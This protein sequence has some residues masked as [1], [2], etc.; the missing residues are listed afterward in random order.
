MNNIK[1]GEGGGLVG[2]Q[3]AYW[4]RGSG[5][6]MTSRAWDVLDGY[7]ALNIII[8]ALRVFRGGDC[9]HKTIP[10]RGKYLGWV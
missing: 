7:F 3:W 2:D 1:S 4:R 5:D 9:T 10:T 6:D 8:V